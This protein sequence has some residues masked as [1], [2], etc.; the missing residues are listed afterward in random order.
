MLKINHFPVCFSSLCIF[1]NRNLHLVS[2][3]IHKMIIKFLFCETSLPGTSTCVLI[4]ISNLTHFLCCNLLVMS[5]LTPS[6]ISANVWEIRLLITSIYP[7]TDG[8]PH[9]KCPVTVSDSDFLECSQNS[10][11]P[12][13]GTIFV[14]FVTH[15]SRMEVSGYFSE[16]C[17]SSQNLHSLLTYT[18]PLVLNY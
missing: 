14:R 6:A 7:C 15:F 10:R 9:H 13:C 12:L 3:Y 2:N 17:E 5:C 1:S 11:G 8:Q 18:A 4:D 16:F